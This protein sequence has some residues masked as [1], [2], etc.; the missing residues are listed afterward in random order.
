MESKEREVLIEL[1]HKY[2]LL[3]VIET[4]KEICARQIETHSAY[5]TDLTDFLKKQEGK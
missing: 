2:G 4:M 5:E 3:A 1:I